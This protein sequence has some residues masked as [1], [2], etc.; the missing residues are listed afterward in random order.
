MADD[1]TDRREPISDDEARRCLA[2]GAGF[3]VM[4]GV[5]D[6]YDTFG[7]RDWRPASREPG[8]I[9]AEVDQMMSMLDQVMG[10]AQRLLRRAM[11]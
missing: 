10:N 6:V 8:D 9:A 5:C 3:A 4:S 7:G 2:F 1:R 11:E